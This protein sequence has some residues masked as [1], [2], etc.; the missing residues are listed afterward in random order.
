MYF[1]LRSTLFFF[2][3]VTEMIK[4]IFRPVRCGLLAAALTVSLAAC[5]SE[6]TGDPSPD[7]DITETN[8]S[9]ET[10]GTGPEPPRPP[11]DGASVSFP[12]LPAGKDNNNNDDSQEQQ[13]VTIEWLGQDDVP[14]GVSVQVKSVR[15]TPAGV[16]EI[17]GSSCDKVQGC[18]DSFAFTSAD[19]SCSVSIKATA[20]NGTPAYMRLAGRCVSKNVQQCD[21][22]LAD[23]GSPIS[24]FQPEGEVPPEDEA[25]SSEEQQP[26]PEESPPPSTG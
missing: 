16:F 10:E 24:L 20:T 3:G 9:P 4:K 11:D 21:E 19:E 8:S 13:C 23:D 14:D 18:T 26:P 25:P 15:I 1:L 22:L 6:D 2:R 5:G 12:D 17:S 7:P